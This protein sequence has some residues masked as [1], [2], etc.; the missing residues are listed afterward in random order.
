MSFENIEFT[1]EDL[2]ASATY[3]E[4]G[5]IHDFMGQWNLLSIMPFKKC[6]IHN[7]PDSLD[8]LDEL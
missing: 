2:F 6:K 7:D 3:I 1:G 5:T 4:S 8:T